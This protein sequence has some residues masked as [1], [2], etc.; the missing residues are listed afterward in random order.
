MSQLPNGIDISTEISGG[1]DLSHEKSDL[2][3][4]VKLALNRIPTLHAQIIRMRYGIDCDIINKRP[5]RWVNKD[6]ANSTNVIAKTLRTSV[7][8][9]SRLLREGMALLRVE[10]ASFEGTN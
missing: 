8:R 5:I 2:S 10:L 1:D 3:E 6:W 4:T 7:K 9:V